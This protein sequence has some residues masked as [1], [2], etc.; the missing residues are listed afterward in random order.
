LPLTQPTAPD[1]RHIASGDLKHWSKHWSV[2][3]E[4]VKSAIETVGN[5]VAA[6]QKELA[7]RGLIQPVE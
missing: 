6:V 3:A 7:R 1:R 5:S 2:P 4:E